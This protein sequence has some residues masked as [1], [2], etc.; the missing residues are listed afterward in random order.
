MK[1]WYCEEEILNDEETVKFTMP[2]SNQALYAHKKCDEKGKELAK[3]KN[4]KNPY[5]IDPSSPTNVVRLIAIIYLVLGIIGAI[6]IWTTIGTVSGNYGEETNPYGVVLGFV[7]LF[8][9][10]ITW[11]LLSV[12]CGMAEDINASKSILKQILEANK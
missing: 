2:N 12:L 10:I 9:S 5:Y 11:A 1:C 3:T 6:F 8:G 7:T 4:H